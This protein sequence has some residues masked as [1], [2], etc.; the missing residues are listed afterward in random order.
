[1]VSIFQGAHFI[2]QYQFLFNRFTPSAYYYGLFFVVRNFLIASVPVT[3]VNEP[4]SQVLCLTLLISASGAVENIL[5]PWKVST[6]S[7]NTSP[8]T[9]LFSLHILQGSLSVGR[10]PLSE[11]LGRQKPSRTSYLK[12]EL[13]THTFIR[14]GMTQGT[15]PVHL[16]S[17]GNCGPALISQVVIP[18][19]CLTGCP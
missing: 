15:V 19:V 4:A 14:V 10:V 17:L 8:D 9:F 18:N 11:H 5:R 7:R 3:Q 13:C 1:M 6:G 12:S 2:R 16:G